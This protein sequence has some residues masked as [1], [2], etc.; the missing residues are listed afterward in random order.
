[1]T[2]R[3]NPVLVLDA[4]GVSYQDKKVVDGVSFT[5]GQGDIACLLGASGCGKTTVLRAIAGFEP[6]V[7]GKITLDQE[8]IAAVGVQ[9]PP[10]QRGVGMVFQD[11]ALFPHLT[12]AR[13]IAFGLGCLRKGERC[14]RVDALLELVGLEE[15][16]ARYPHELSGGQQ[17]RV[18]VARALAPCP[19]LLLLDE[20][21]SGL[22]SALRDTLG[23]DVRS[24]L[25]K[26]NMTA[27]MVTHDQDEARSLCDAIGLMDKGK[28]ERWDR[29]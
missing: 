5:V 23:H 1:M 3:E 10:H 9:K 15:Y 22:D 19:K 27:I 29:P 18:A 12:V 4:I 14:R 6:V 13:N 24:V 11:Y 20:P 28:I 8:T 7:A 25:K 16:G 21:F 26:E 2:A 17:Q